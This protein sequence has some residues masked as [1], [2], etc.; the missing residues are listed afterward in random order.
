[1]FKKKTA[2]A[3]A[4]PN[5]ALNHNE[6]KYITKFEYVCVMLSRIGGQFGTTLTGTL[7]AAFLHELYFGPIGVSSEEIA[8]ILKSTIKLSYILLTRIICW[9]KNLY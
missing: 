9:Q 8:D 3:T 5:G 6:G 1:M 7:A 4:I 2:P